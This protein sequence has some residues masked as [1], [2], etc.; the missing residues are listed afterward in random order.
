MFDKSKSIFFRESLYH[1]EEP[2]IIDT[3]KRVENQ[4][5]YLNPS[6]PINRKYG[7]RITFNNSLLENIEKSITYE[8]NLKI[9]SNEDSNFFTSNIIRDNL[10][11][12]DKLPELLM[13]ELSLKIMNTI[14]PIQSK[15]DKEF[16]RHIDIANHAEILK[17]WDYLQDDLMVK[18]DG[19][20]IQDIIFQVDKKILNIEKLA[21]SFQKDMFWAALFHPILG[22]YGSQQSR[23]QEMIFPL[24]EDDIIL[25]EGTQHIYPYETDYGTI[26]IYYEGENENK[27]TIK[28]SYDID[29]DT[30]TIKY[31]TIDYNNKE[32]GE[33]ILFS[34][35]DL[36]VKKEE[37]LFDTEIEVL[38]TEVKK[39][40]SFWS[41]LD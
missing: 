25:F 6:L 40:K 27:G 20:L 13:D 22:D 5:F 11:I 19:L 36:E 33:S 34:A 30:H 14:Y 28:A 18:Y 24:G 21:R 2:Q 38:P 16:N 37:F 12:N 32:T 9:T 8:I 10:R 41:F 39:K 3:R 1:K 4:T 7:V 23:A 35:Y 29:I 31:I 17:K 15:V 26:K